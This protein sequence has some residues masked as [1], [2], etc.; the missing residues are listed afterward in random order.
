MTQE[1]IDSLPILDLIH[2]SDFYSLSVTNF[3]GVEY[4][5]LIF[6]GKREEGKNYYEWEGSQSPQSLFKIFKLKNQT[7]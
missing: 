2:R 3:E 6:K 4:W 1:K 7:P 5:V